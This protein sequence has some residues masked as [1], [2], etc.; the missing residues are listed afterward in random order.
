VLHDDG[1]LRPQRW[2]AAPVSVQGLPERGLAISA[3]WLGEPLR[4]VLTSGALTIE[5]LRDA[6]GLVQVRQP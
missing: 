6:A 2:Q 3:E 5:V 1:P 4:L